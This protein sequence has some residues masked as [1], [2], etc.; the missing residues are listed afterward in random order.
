M[1]Y[2]KNILEGRECLM[3]HEF[4]DSYLDLKLDNYILTFDDGL[5]NHYTTYKKIIKKFPDIRLYYFI[6]TDII[7]NKDLNK[8]E[9][10]DN[11]NSAIAHD[12]YFANNDKRAFLTYDQI[13]EMSKCLNITIGVHGHKHLNIDTLKKEHKLLNRI[14]NFRTDSHSMLNEITKFIDNKIIDEKHVIYC[15]PYNQ[16]SELEMG[17]LKAEFYEQHEAI[18]TIIGPGR[19]SIEELEEQK[20]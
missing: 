10:I 1:S 15:T 5:Y 8:A 4:K 9:Q 3:I 16:Y 12:M 19:K 2:N 13:L 17:I 11:I 7:Y 18:L 20:S 6:S 14:E